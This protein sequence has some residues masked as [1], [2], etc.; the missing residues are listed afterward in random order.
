MK[1]NGTDGEENMKKF[2]K[3][4]SQLKPYTIPKEFAVDH[5]EN[6]K[7]L[8]ED[9]NLHATWEMRNIMFAIA[10]AICSVCHASTVRF[11][12]LRRRV[13][14]VCEVSPTHFLRTFP[15]WL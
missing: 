9:K 3:K 13:H 7:L 8:I 1:N 5:L 10:F 4:L 12:V 6:I 2:I 11:C 15:K 14:R